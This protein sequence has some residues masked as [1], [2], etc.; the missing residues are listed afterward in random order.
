[1]ETFME[2]RQLK[3]FCAV[4]ELGSFT[5]AA[6]RVNTVQSNVTMRVKELE[7]ELNRE[8]FIRKKSG[9]VLTSAGETFLGYARRILQLTDESRSVLM[10]TGSPTG[11]L[12][13]G[14][15][16]TTAAIRLPQVLTKYR[17]QYPTSS[18]RC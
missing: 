14:S 5:A 9:V 15:M 16:E 10:D 2:M 18:C 3:I 4:A 17:E 7:A 8:L 12:R 6:V 1:M 13:L 11:L